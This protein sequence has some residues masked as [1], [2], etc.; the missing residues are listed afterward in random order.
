MKSR[1]IWPKGTLL[2]VIFPRFLKGMK[3]EFGQK[4]ENVNVHLF[5]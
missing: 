2:E 5:F 3:I 1:N 4:S